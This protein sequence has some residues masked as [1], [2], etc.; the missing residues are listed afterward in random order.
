[1]WSTQWTQHAVGAPSRTQQ[2]GPRII[3]PVHHL[4]AIQHATWLMVHQ[5]YS[6]PKH[7]VCAPNIH[8]IPLVHQTCR[9]CTKWTQQPSAT[10]HTTRA[11]HA[12][13]SVRLGPKPCD[14]PGRPGEARGE[15]QRWAVGEGRWGDRTTKIGEWGKRGL[16]HD[17]P[18]REARGGPQRWAAGWGGGGATRSRWARVTNRRISE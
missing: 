3:A 1:M 12:C 11:P 14:L 2:T 10:K 13:A 8:N 15:P 5:R 16:G 6:A 17:L 7:T 18:G 4:H 9:W